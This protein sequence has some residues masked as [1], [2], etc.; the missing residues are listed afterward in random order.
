VNKLLVLYTQL[1][2]AVAI[3]AG[4][5]RRKEEQLGKV[6]EIRFV[7]LDLSQS[8]FCTTISFNC[9]QFWYTVTCFMSHKNLIGKIMISR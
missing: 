3:L 2:T 6:S 9:C 7:V 5:E 4:W 8:A 1:N